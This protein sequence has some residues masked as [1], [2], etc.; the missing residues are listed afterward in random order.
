MSKYLVHVPKPNNVY[1][2]TG[3]IYINSCKIKN[4][5]KENQ[6]IILFMIKW[7]IILVYYR[8]KFYGYHDLV[9]D[10]GHHICLASKIGA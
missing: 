9:G 1:L 10:V 7:L 6:T 2:L 8:V 5:Y 3:N 4:I